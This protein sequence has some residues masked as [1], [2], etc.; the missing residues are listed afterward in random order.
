MK[1]VCPKCN[2]NYQIDDSKV[3][4]K[5][6]L[7][8]KCSVCQNKFRVFKEE[9]GESDAPK[10]N[11]ENEITHGVTDE[12]ASQ[13]QEVNMASYHDE[14]ADNAGY[15]DS[16]GI[17]FDK[18]SGNSDINIGNDRFDNDSLFDDGLSD[19]AN[20]D[21]DI[22]SLFSDNAGSKAGKSNSAD[23]L[24]DDLPNETASNSSKKKS[25]I[26]SLF[27]DE[28]DDLFS[29]ISD[30][31]PK[32][33]SEAA[34]DFLKDLFGEKPAAKNNRN[35]Y[36]RNKTTGK[37][38]GPVDEAQV[39]DLMINGE[40]TED[41][42]ISYDGVN[43]NSG[44]NNANAASSNSANA[45]DGNLKASDEDKLG[46]SFDSFI[47]EEGTAIHGEASLSED[48][49]E[50]LDS[51][52]DHVYIP[53]DYNETS[54]DQDKKLKKGK[55]KNRKNSSLFFYVGISVATL[56]VLAIIIGSAYYFYVKRNNSADVLDNISEQ[57]AVNTGT[58][59]DV[60]DALDKDLPEEYIKS[61]GILKQYI[62]PDDSAPSAV[63]LDGQ[64]KLNLLISYN[65]KVESTS[66][67]SEKIALAIKSAP[68][69]IDLVKAMA[70]CLYEEKK[71]DDAATL[72][73]PFADKNDQEVFYILG[74][75]ASGKHDYEK[76]ENF[77]NTGF[78][79]SGGKN[80]KIMYALAKM[81]F[82]NGDAQSA[83]AF[84]NRIIS[85]T[86]NYI[87]AYLLK[88]TILVGEGKLSE[89][90]KLLLGIDT[91]VIAK[92]DDSLKAEYYQSLAS[93]A[94]N[95]GKIKEAVKYYE[96]AVEIN[97]ADTLAVTTLADYYVQISDLN[98]AMEY[99][100]KALKI[101]VKYSAA[102]IGKT[103]IYVSLGQKEKIYLELAKLD[104]KTLNDP[105]LL[106]RIAK[107]YSNIGDKAK[108]IEFY[109]LA[110]KSDP[111][112]NEP[113]IAK[114][115][116]LL[117][118]FNKTKELEQIVVVLE[119]LGKDRYPYHLIKAIV[120]HKNGDFKSA[121]EHFKIA[122]EKNTAG[123]E[124]VF[125]FYGEFLKD[126]QKYAEASKMLN[127]AYK[128]A[129]NNYEYL[130]A[131]V[132]SLEKEKKW[133]SVISLLESKT[134]VEKKMYRSYASL[135][136][137]YLHVKEYD[138]AL[139]SINRSIELSS[140]NRSTYYLKAKILYDM[141]R[142]ADAEKEIDTAVVLDMRNFDNYMLYAR[143][144]S[145]RGDFKGAVEKIEAAEKIDPTDQDLLLMKGVVYK[146]LDDYRN[147]I[148][149]FN[150][151]TDK[152]LKKEAYLE[153]GE[154]YWQLNNPKKAL[155]Y[156]QKALQS[157]NRDAEKLIAS[158]FYD[159]GEINKSIIYYKRALKHNKNDAESLR[160]LGY[161]YKERE[162]ISKAISYFRRYLK[163]IHDSNEKRMIEDEIY[164]LQ[165]NLPQQPQVNTNVQRKEV[166]ADE[167]GEDMNE[168][169]S[170]SGQNND[171]NDDNAE[172]EAKSIKELY[173]QATSL[174]NEDPE[175]A[176]HLFKEILKTTQ[177][178]DEY[179][180]KA[181]KALEQLDEN[182]N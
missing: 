103:E 100:D 25:D 120:D 74:L 137:S 129:P 67:I 59:A 167:E 83:M 175:K 38:I 98:K 51:N 53:D 126:D 111:S 117:L 42:D 55:K 50:N 41:D 88:T 12:M 13:A 17:S 69:N 143:I 20:S 18:K 85:N 151:V 149:Y 180:K 119:K 162:E 177:K 176:K 64:I 125:F 77:F 101:D 14:I 34:D 161:I 157:G 78:L 45:S 165:Q 68:N 109:D 104:L 95:N 170:E 174:K 148:K 36:F 164:F 147:A 87:K 89:A 112:Y 122:E 28:D 130:Q 171:E 178:E 135:A 80:V 39:D 150:K 92:A 123:D 96:K 144:L 155:Q 47:F 16:K 142:Y 4:A 134:F 54:S 110:I 106:S 24:F 19:S 30:D 65:K 114:A 163:T 44:E 124:R 26:D 128:V 154:S 62:K 32:S 10:E 9:S 141:G 113:Y 97:Q 46:E 159:S 139:N 132:G 8:V 11:S 76:A 35:V 140:Q 136:N 81:K 48:I 82:Q 127:K 93:V 61:I 58:L 21:S 40:I 52:V 173:E 29:D 158:I 2:T 172:S 131:Y 60:R 107:I 73:Q 71:Y 153:I 166:E 31:K 75:L 27:D 156:L 94:N 79:H 72:L 116:I 5:K 6:G 66:S 1:I 91:N 86:P 84:I 168:E 7:Q 121:A 57:I 138:K 133:Q 56:A 3:P 108:A 118:D 22:D 145:K 15:S 63:G 146:N 33:K 182:N 23:A 169:N 102:I 37:I 179:Y 181:F 160:K 90:E 70:L 49:D 105:R 115:Q 152:A 99:Y 43:W